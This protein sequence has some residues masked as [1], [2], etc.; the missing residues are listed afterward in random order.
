MRLFEREAILI[1]KYAYLSFCVYQN[2]CMQ[3]PGLEDFNTPAHIQSA[4]DR[5]MS[6]QSLADFLDYS[7]R[8]NFWLQYSLD[9]KK[10]IQVDE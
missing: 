4:Y 5:A 7:S 2:Y 9:Q 1:R 6:Q 8:F 10:F 3:H